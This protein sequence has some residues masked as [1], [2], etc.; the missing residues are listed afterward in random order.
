MFAGVDNRSER[1]GLAD[2]LGEALSPLA[3]RID[4]A[5]VFGSVAK[6]TDT[7]QSDIDL[8]IISR[9]LAYSDAMIALADA[10]STLRRKVNPTLYTA[11]E[12]QRKLKADGKKRRSNTYP[13]NAKLRF[14]D[15]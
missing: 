11:S 14:I 4:I 8:F 9:D 7:A 12:L 15:G 5:F 1:S 13:D 10:E 6:G 2:L 3:D